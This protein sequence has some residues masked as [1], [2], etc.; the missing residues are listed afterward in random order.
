MNKT[1]VY[2][3]HHGFDFRLEDRELTA[4]ECY[5]P[6]CGQSDELIGIYETEQEFADKL[7]QLFL[8]GYDLAAC[9]N[10]NELIRKYCPAE[11][12]DGRI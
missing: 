3:C 7:K 10:Y 1:Y 12:Q 8:E 5:C 4:E 2:I 6:I 9:D 11:L